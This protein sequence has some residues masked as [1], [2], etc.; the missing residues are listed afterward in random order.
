MD[1]SAV[2]TTSTVA[3]VTS[4]RGCTIASSRVGGRGRVYQLLRRL[5]S[6]GWCMN[7]STLTNGAILPGQSERQPPLPSLV[8]VSSRPPTPPLV[9]SMTAAEVAVSAQEAPS[10]SPVAVFTRAQLGSLPSLGSMRQSPKVGQFKMTTLQPSILQYFPH[11][12]PKLNTELSK[13]KTWQD[14]G[15][16]LHHIIAVVQTVEIDVEGLRG[17]LNTHESTWNPKL[18]L[19]SA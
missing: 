5:Y 9:P 7:Q 3:S 2:V 1:S 12:R 8:E 17:W 15:N 13:Y 10:A 14:H 18:R 11:I 6:L 16:M 19:S 4:T